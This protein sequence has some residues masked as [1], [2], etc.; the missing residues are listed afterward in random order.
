MAPLETITSSPPNLSADLGTLASLQLPQDQVYVRCNFDLPSD[1]PRA[2]AI[3]IPGQLERRVSIEQILAMPKVSLHMVLECAGNGRTLMRPVPEGTPWTLGGVS[4]IVVEG[5]MLRSVLGQ[6]PE[7]VA[8]VVFTGADVGEVEPEGT[9]NYQFSIGRDLAMS[10]VPMIVTHIGGEPLTMEHGAPARL[11]V[12]G[13]YAMKSVK[14]LTRIEATTE[15]FSGHFVEKYRYYGSA[16]HLER[17]PVGPIAV[18][19]VITRPSH[20]DTVESPVAISGSAWASGGVESVEL[21]ADGGST[22]QAA[23][24]D[25]A[26]SR[27]APRLWQLT[28]ELGT[29]R[30]E[31]VSRARATNGEAQPL[32]PRWNANGYANNVVH[33]VTVEVE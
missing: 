28:L 11:V 18:R 27:F 1:P 21:S 8:D 12:P 26:P 3:A 16:E 6:L 13:H 23:E 20:G 29:G 24:L 7:D 9:I 15:Q 2:I 5:P 17:A 25:D 32:E 14:W 31:I 33:R 19:S 22:W 10:D 4:P 30:H